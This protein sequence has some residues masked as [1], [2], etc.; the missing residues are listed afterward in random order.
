MFSS[1]FK[2]KDIIIDQ[3][4]R[5]PVDLIFIKSEPFRSDGFRTSEPTCPQNN[6]RRSRVTA[7]RTYPAGEQDP[8]V[9]HMAPLSAG[10]RKVFSVAVG[11]VP[12][13]GDAAPVSPCSR[14]ARP[15]PT[16]TLIYFTLGNAF[17]PHRSVTRPA[18]RQPW[19][20]ESV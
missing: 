8:A 5:T 6:E 15:L 10:W 7:V 14:R 12:E 19:M 20:T 9:T 13:T 17:R 11:G 1:S 2:P 4:L 3:G 18:P 16:E